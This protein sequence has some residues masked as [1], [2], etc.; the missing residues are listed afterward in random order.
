MGVAGGVGGIVIGVE[1]AALSDCPADDVAVGVE[2][3][4]FKILL[5]GG[6]RGLCIYFCSG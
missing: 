6:D 2:D 3:L 1:A 5:L 4:D